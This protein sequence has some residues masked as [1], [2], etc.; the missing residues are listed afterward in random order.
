MIKVSFL[1]IWRLLALFDSLGIQQIYVWIGAVTAFFGVLM[2]IS[3]TDAKKLL[4][5][6][7]IS[8]MGFILAAYGIGTPLAMTAAFTHVINHSLFKSLLFLAVGVA[9]HT[10]GQ[11]N[12]YRMGYWGGTTFLTLIPFLAGA[13]SISGIPPFNG[14]ASKALIVEGLKTQPPAYAFILVSSAFTVASFIK[15]SRIFWA[16]RSEFVGEERWTG[17]QLAIGRQAWLH[18]PLYI[19]AAACIGT[20]ILPG[21]FASS[22]SRIL[23]MQTPTPGDFVFAMKPLVS[24]LA[25]VAGGV[26]LFLLVL[27]K[28]GAS[29]MRFFRRSA[30]GLNGSLMLLVA[31]FL[32]LCLW[33]WLISGSAA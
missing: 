16:K 9:M 28:P 18:A 33:I 25:V 4:G 17:R 27:T 14:Y 5:Y 29:V 1:V 30:A 7:S 26:L 6:H 2:A 22:Y 32:V 10:S 24:Q 3:Q 19:L 23:G 20:G 31:G 8:Q 13:S 11:R 15:L 21:F 12:I